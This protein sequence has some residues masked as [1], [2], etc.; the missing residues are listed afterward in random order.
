MLTALD[1]VFSPA[2]SPRLKVLPDNETGGDGTKN[3]KD[4]KSSQHW[5]RRVRKSRN[6]TVDGT[7]PGTQWSR[8][9]TQR[10]GSGIHVDH[11]VETREHDSV[12]TTNRQKYVPE[13][14]IKV[15]TCDK[16]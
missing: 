14:I 11:N 12:S 3:T 15:Y 1:A 5:R 16:R 9:D 13:V 2:P 10:N 7:S 4:C 6:T 8:C